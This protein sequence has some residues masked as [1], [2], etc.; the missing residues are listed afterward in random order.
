MQQPSAL[1]SC[2]WL[3]ALFAEGA[4]K[5]TTTCPLLLLFSLRVKVLLIML[6]GIVFCVFKNFRHE[7]ITGV[8]VIISLLGLTEPFFAM[9]LH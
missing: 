8:A 1:L 5:G 7:W 2:A 9:T 6:V 3:G 4:Q